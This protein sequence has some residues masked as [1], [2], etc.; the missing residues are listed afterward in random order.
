MKEDFL[1]FFFQC[2]KA[3]LENELSVVA[4]DSNGNI[5]GSRMGD[6]YTVSSCPAEY[7]PGVYISNISSMFKSLQHEIFK[8]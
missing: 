1:N 2:R 3:W 7:F 6:D 8:E 4:I 5:V